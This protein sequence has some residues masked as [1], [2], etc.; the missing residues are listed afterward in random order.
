MEKE[1]AYRDQDE[2]DTEASDEEMMSETAD[3]EDGPAKTTS[4]MGNDMENENSGNSNQAAIDEFE[5]TTTDDSKNV[6]QIFLRAN[7][8][9]TIAMVQMFTKLRL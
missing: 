1:K 5:E 4:E 6:A 7:F 3:N 2:S 9:A 8:L